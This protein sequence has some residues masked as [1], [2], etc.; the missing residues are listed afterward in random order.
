VSAILADYAR[1]GNPLRGLAEIDSKPNILHLFSLP[2][3]PEFLAAQE[4]FFAAN[5]WFSATR[6]RG[7]S[8]GF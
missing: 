8:A 1:H 5:P 7:R 4:T 3:A 6:D 2:R